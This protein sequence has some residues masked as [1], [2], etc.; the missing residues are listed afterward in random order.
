MP[1]PP[2]ELHF[3]GMIDEPSQFDTLATWQDF[4]KQ[5]QALPNRD[6]SKQD[7][8]EMAKTGG[9]PPLSSFQEFG[10]ERNNLDIVFLSASLRVSDEGCAFG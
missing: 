1:H 7:L 2:K 6:S 3:T 4:Q 5:V 8:L 10:S 9:H